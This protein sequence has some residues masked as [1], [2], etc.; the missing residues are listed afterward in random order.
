MVMTKPKVLWCADIAAK[1]GF[2]RVTE[3]ILPYLKNHYEVVIIGCNWWGDPCEWQKDFKMYPSSNRFQQEPFG[4]Q[5]IRQIVEVEKPDLVFTMNDIWIINQQYNAIKDLHEKGDFKFVGYYPMDSYGWT[6]SI[7][8]TM[9]QWDTSICYTTFG[10]QEII[11]AGL[12]KPVS[13]IPHGVDLSAF[14]PG[15]KA[16]ARAALGLDEDLFIVLNANR[17]QWRK[18]ID[19]TIDAFSKFAGLYP[20]DDHIKLY[21]HMGL[22]DQGWDI[23]PLFGKSMTAHGMNPN[24]RIVMTTN[25]AGPPGVNVETLRTIYHAADVGINTCCGEGWGL[26]NFEMAACKIPQVVPNHT[27]CKEIFEG[28]GEL[29]DTCYVSIDMNL[30]RQLPVPSSVHAAQILQNLYEDEVRREAVAEAQYKRVTDA[31]FSWPV[32]TQQ[33]HDCFKE[34]LKQIN[35][36]FE[37]PK[38]TPV[39][40][41]RRKKNKRLELQSI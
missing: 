7:L 26:V 39:K 14:Y 11:N 17:N 23:M 9:P 8:D 38:A 6:G 5:R 16:E 29:I 41:K 3:G 21:M 30:N 13:V 15:D 20:D 1:T 19:V 28:T 35:P 36:A 22:K 2:S 24:N 27:S 33:F 31:Q 18:K 4:C 10:A 37:Q 40:P 25:Q 34:T 12:Q 32:I